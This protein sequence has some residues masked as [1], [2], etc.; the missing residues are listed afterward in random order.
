M[1]FRKIELAFRSLSNI[2]EHLHQSF[3]FYTMTSS[4]SYVSISNYIALGAMPIAALFLCALS[5]ASQQSTFY[6]VGLFS[7][8]FGVLY[9]TLMIIAVKIF[10]VNFSLGM[11]VLNGGSFISYIIAR[12]I[13]QIYVKNSIKPVTCFAGSLVLTMLLLLNFGYAVFA[14][15]F[16]APILLYSQ[17]NWRWMRLLALCVCPVAILDAAWFL[18]S[19][20]AYWIA[21]RMATWNAG[22]PFLVIQPLLL[23]SIMEPPHRVSLIDKKEIACKKD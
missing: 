11:V 12:Q 15:I 23:L 21:I 3:F 9:A 4:E 14:G 1:N 2:L 22:L 19:Q 7:M 13:C 18:N 5:H 16:Y 8:I 6:A 20:W 17:P 10:A